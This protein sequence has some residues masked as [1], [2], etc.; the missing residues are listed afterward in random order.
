[1]Q[2]K[3]SLFQEC[4]NAMLATSNAVK[5]PVIPKANFTAYTSFSLGS[6]TITFLPLL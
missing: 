6:R 2:M 1:M 4:R 3:T 5:H